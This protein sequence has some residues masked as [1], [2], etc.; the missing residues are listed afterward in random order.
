MGLLKLPNV[1]EESVI[2]T[3]ILVFFQFT[4]GYLII[5]IIIH[6]GAQNPLKPPTYTFHIGR[7]KR[8][9]YD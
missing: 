7:E 2:L 5:L 4:I 8:N 1:L 9:I 6:S 3:Q